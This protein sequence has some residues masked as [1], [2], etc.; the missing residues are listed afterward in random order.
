MTVPTEGRAP[1]RARAI[2]IVAAIVALLAGT[3]V[4]LGLRKLS[5]DK[6]A[7][8][9]PSAGLAGAAAGAKTALVT[10]GQLAVNFTSFD[11]RTLPQ[12][13]ANTAKHFAPAY[14]KAYLVQSKA[15][16]PAIRKAKA[17]AVS[18]VVATGLSS[19]DPTAG[20][21]TVL[22]ALNIDTK[23]SATPAGAPSYYRLEVSLE[24]DGPEWLAT[25]MLPA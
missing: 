13:R 7:A 20:T 21:A 16:A 22:V 8:D 3:F 23:N 11:Y 6:D 2:L 5:H 19:Y 12:D 10:G 15:L 17:V 1:D 24:K 4:G 14:A 18:S 25:K 9:H